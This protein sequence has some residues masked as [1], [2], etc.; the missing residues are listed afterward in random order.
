MQYSI[1]INQKAFIE[2]FPT[3][4]IKDASIVDFLG[5]FA[6]SAEI[7]KRVVGTVI[8]YWFNY[9]KIANEM[10]ILGLNA[11]SVRKRMRGICATGILLAHEANQGAKSFFAF[12]NNYQKTRREHRDENTEVEKTSVLKSRSIGTKIPKLGQNIGTEIPIDHYTNKDHYTN[13]QQKVVAAEKI[14]TFEEEEKERG[15]H[16]GAPSAS[17]PF[18]TYEPFDLY[19]QVE[20]IRTDYKMR[21]NLTIVAKVPQP[22]FEPY[23]EAFKAKEEAIGCNHTSTR[24]FRAHF[25]NFCRARYR[26][27]RA[28]PAPSAQPSGSLPKNLRRV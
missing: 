1:N 22:F 19:E 20:A 6:H 16:S 8:Y 18:R 5:H 17:Q 2:N 13:Q 3:L 12:G 24:E 10:P 14:T 7:E 25:I 9:S 4:D 11:E 15:N 27:E 23:L 28:Q 21:E 26:S